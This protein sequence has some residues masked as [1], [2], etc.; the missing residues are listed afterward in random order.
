MEDD[1]N[2]NAGKKRSNERSLT[3]ASKV[4]R[5]SKKRKT[6]MRKKDVEN[7][8]SINFQLH[9]GDNSTDSVVFSSVDNRVLLMLMIMYLSCS[10]FYLEE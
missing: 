9:V 1:N 8:S 6:F 3:Q 7:T 4:R 2:K 10:K 5:T